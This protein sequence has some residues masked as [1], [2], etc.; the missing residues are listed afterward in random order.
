MAESGNIARFLMWIGGAIFL[1][2]LIWSFA[3]KLPFLRGLGRLP[4]DFNW[5]GQGWEVHF[6]LATSLILSLLLSAAFWLISYIKS[7][8]GK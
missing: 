4:G 6:P 2:G 1:I 7:G 5:R 8:G 3:D